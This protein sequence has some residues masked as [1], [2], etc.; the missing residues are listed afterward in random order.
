MNISRL[1][2]GTVLVAGISFVSSGALAL[3][4]SVQIKGKIKLMGCEV[5]TGSKDQTVD[6]KRVNVP[7]SYPSGSVVA[8]K[9]FTIKLQNCESTAVADVSMSGTPDSFNADYFALDSTSQDS[10]K[11]IALRIKSTNGEVQNPSGKVVTWRFNSSSSEQLL[12]YNGALIKTSDITNGKV[13]VNA[14]FSVNYR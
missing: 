7:V 14:E 11:G 6:F 1:F 4:A 2:R 3:D 8:E 9:P 5:D 10:A 13:N 12:T